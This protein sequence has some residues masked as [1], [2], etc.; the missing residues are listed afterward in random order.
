[1]SVAARKEWT[2]ES[3]YCNC[4]LVVMARVPIQA[5][6]FSSNHTV[7][8][9]EALAA[10]TP[11]TAEWIQAQEFNYFTLNPLTVIQILS[12]LGRITNF[13]QWYSFEVRDMVEDDGPVVKRIFHVSLSRK[14]DIFDLQIK[15]D[16]L[17]KV[18]MSYEESR[19]RVLAS[20]ERPQN[21]VAS[22]ES[23]V[24]QAPKSW[25]RR[26]LA[27]FHRD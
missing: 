9:L 23:Q 11:G 16:P 20:Q 8:D 7:F 5:L 19:R 3:G 13:Q 17:Q 26:M 21:A 15:I 2:G 22:Q 1:M 24:G 10:E 27:V 4:L 18:V 6:H 25:V 14:E 12:Q